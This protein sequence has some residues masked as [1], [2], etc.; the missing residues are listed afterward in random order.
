MKISYISCPCTFL[1][2]HLYI[3]LWILIKLEK[4]RSADG[5]TRSE[6]INR[7]NLQ[8]KTSEKVSPL[9]RQTINQM[10]SIF[11]VNKLGS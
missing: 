11:R 3:P 1:A 2:S 6:N 10:F 5:E 7:V 8:V 9:N 4:D